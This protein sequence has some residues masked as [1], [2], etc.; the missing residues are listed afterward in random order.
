MAGFKL[1]GRHA[2]GTIVAIVPV[3]AA[4][5]LSA[6]TVGPQYLRPAQDAPAA[7]K[8]SAPGAAAPLRDDW[9]TLFGDAQLNALIDEGLRANQDVE[10]ALARFDQARAQLGVTRA[11]RSPTLA[12]E[13]SVARARTSQNVSNAFPV[14]DTTVYQLPFDVSYEIDFWGRV[15]RSVASVRAQLEA[16][17][18]A[19]AALR[20]SVAAEIATTYLQS[21]SYVREADA[22]R[23]AV[24]LREQSRLLAERRFR[25]GVV[26]ELDL[27]RANSELAQARADFEDITRRRELSVHALAVLLGRTA[28]DFALPESV[29]TY[30]VP[31]VPA[32]LPAELLERRPDIGQAERLLAAS[33]EQIGI[34]EAARFPTIQLTAFGGVASNEL[35]LLGNRASAIWSLGPTLSLPILDGGRIDSNVALAQARYREAQASYRKIV[36]V[37]FREVEDALSDSA[38][39]GMRARHLRDATASSRD[40]AKVSRARYERGVA[41]FLEVIDAE[42]TALFI[43]RAEIQNDQA[44]LAVSVSLIKALGGG[45]RSAAAVAGP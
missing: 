20:L 40:A 13:P 16:S 11:D 42:R 38:A 41:G 21:A 4:A 29:A 28:P 30:G 31:D 10:V 36:L 3:V 2:M 25:A 32:G 45:W 44:R 22:L 15:R 17:S 18:D 8:K 12:F 37:A 7:W 23:R 24:D 1:P 35:S 26:S 27:L 39:L 19:A 33:S 6:C 43:E 5:L 14:P 9:W 34:A